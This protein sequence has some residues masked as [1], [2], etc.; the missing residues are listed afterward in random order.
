M[1][2]TSRVILLFEG[3]TGS[4]LLGNL[5]NQ[6]KSVSF[7]GEEV[8]DLY[9]SGWEAQC[10]W[11]DSLFFD[12]ERFQEKYQDPRIQDT[13]TVLGFKVKLR[14]I[15]SEEGLKHYIENNNL[16]IIHMFRRNLVKQTVSSIRAIDLY[17]QT[18]FYNLSK[19]QANLN[20][21][22][23]KIPKRRFNTIFLQLLELEHNL[24]VFLAKL[25]VPIIYIAYED[26][27]KKPQ[28]VL[29]Q[30]FDRIGVSSC[31]VNPN[32]VKLTSDD[33]S[34]VI[35]NLDELINFYSDTPY[36]WMFKSE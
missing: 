14:D 2:I 15:A 27:Y 30:I 34:L 18:G 24:Q 7:L 28:N 3:R 17:K 29:D 19:K 9:K 1:N 33:L 5:L 6:N 4:S 22:A 36:G 23:Y 12:V 31:Q 25:E 13:S 35:T 16:T 32:L 20:L 8:A 10:D 21:G 11:I 26:L